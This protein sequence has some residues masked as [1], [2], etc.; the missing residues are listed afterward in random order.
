MLF[1]YTSA[2]NSPASLMPRLPIA[3]SLN[4]R[5]TEISGLLDTG[6]AINVMSYQIGIELGAKRD[7]Q[8]IAVPLTGSLGQFEARAL[9]VFAAHP[10]ITGNQ[11]VQLVFAWTQAQNAPLI[12]GQMNFFLE[13]DVCFYRSRNNF[14]VR[15]KR[16]N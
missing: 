9:V 14:D 11:P 3:L 12:L 4:N 10:Q 1:Q 7:E 13:F 16:N 8:T 6:S 5:T 15:L 2:D